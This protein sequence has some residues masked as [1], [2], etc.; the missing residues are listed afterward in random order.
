ME[1][2]QGKW[3]RGSG[4]SFAHES[5]QTYTATC[6]SFAHEKLRRESSESPTKYP[7]KLFE[8]K[9][10][11]PIHCSSYLIIT[12]I[13]HFQGN[14]WKFVASK[15]DSKEGFTLLTPRSW[16]KVSLSLTW[17]CL[18]LISIWWKGWTLFLVLVHQ[19]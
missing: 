12:H 13:K 7:H 19:I 1:V 17:F 8:E 18:D 2:G 6:F 11:Q 16:I 15:I 14:G 4:F 10:A 5:L 3:D 9:T